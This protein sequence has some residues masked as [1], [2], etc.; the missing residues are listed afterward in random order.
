MILSSLILDIS[1]KNKKALD[2]RAFLLILKALNVLIEDIKS[3]NP[4][5]N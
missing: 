1:Y 4:L 5:S 3:K 2:K